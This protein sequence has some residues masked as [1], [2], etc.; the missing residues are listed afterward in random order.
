MLL[1]SATN[2][3]EAEQAVGAGVDAIV[4]Q[5]E[6]G[7][8]RGVFDPGCARR[9]ARRHREALTRLLVA[10]RSLPVIVAAGGFMDGVGVAA[11]LDLGARPV[12]LG[13][14]F[15]ACPESSADHFLATRC[16]ARVLR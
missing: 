12:Q 11:V 7:C 16:S 8:H 15:V 3:V 2:L 13:T 4:A 9:P 6:A 10:K 5:G 14:A 1:S